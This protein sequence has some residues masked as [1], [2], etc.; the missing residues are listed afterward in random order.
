MHYFTQYPFLNHI[1]IFLLPLM[2]YTALRFCRPWK[3][4]NSLEQQ[5]QADVERSHSSVQFMFPLSTCQQIADYKRY[6][7]C[8]T[9]MMRPCSVLVDLELIGWS[10]TFWTTSTRRLLSAI[11]ALLSVHSSGHAPQF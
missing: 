3:I 4:P 9:D 5:N 6:L 10:Y 8:L 2:P 11:E 7:G 1:C